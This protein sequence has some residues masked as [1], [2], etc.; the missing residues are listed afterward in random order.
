MKD[1]P[2]E[3]LLH[4]FEFLKVNDD[5]SEEEEKHTFLSMSLVCRWFYLQAAPI[6]FRSIVIDT[7]GLIV[8]TNSSNKH[9]HL[10]QA[11]QEGDPSVEAHINHIKQCTIQA[12]GGTRGPPQII[13]AAVRTMLRTLRS[14]YSLTI[15]SG[16]IDPAVLRIICSIKRLKSIQFHHSIFS[17]LKPLDTRKISLARWRSVEY[18]DYSTLRSIPLL[19]RSV[20]KLLDCKMTSFKTNNVTLTRSLL[21]SRCQLVQLHLTRVRGLKALASF[22]S[23]QC[24]LTHLSILCIDIRFL[25]L[26]YVPSIPAG[27]LTTLRSVTLPLPLALWLIHLDALTHISLLGE[28]RGTIQT[29][30]SQ[31]FF[32]KVWLSSL[33][34]LR[35]C[36]MSLQNLELPSNLLAAQASDAAKPQMPAPSQILVEFHPDS[37]LSNEKVCFNLLRSHPCYITNNSASRF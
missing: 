32:E 6:A 36:S 28:T 26:A 22:L 29:T 20:T 11:I 13:S 16:M 15:R 8:K 24:S 19:E 1:I 7:H 17:G 3:L 30:F 18:I 34:L 33:D 5:V 2:V 4:I 27:S 35:R 9:R 10:C 37:G 23:T 14:L 21:I 12:P 31:Q 25:N